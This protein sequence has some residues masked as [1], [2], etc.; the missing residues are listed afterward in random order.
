MGD[1]IWING[2]FGSGKTQTAWE[3]HRRLPGSYVYD[4]ENAG[5]YIRDNL[6]ADLF[7]EDFQE[8]KMWR[9]FNYLMLSYLAEHYE[10]IILVPMT[11]PDPVKFE[12]M[13]GRLQREGR[14]MQAFVLWA[15]RDVL[16]HRLSV[17]GE[18]SSSWAALQIE[19]C[20]HG[21][22]SPALG[23]R[24]ETEKLPVSDV[25]NRIAELAGLKL[26]S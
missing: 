22:Q 5:Y 26:Q 2:A 8:F 21:L 17:R 12:E 1:I 25:A 20:L 11:V 4:P 3:L 13:A 6:P 16:L 23:R 14:Q 24:I 15:S 9:E 10:G 19:R 18:G 7:K